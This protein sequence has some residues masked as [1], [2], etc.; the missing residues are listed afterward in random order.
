M[1]VIKYLKKLVHIF[2]YFDNFGFKDHILILQ[3]KFYQIIYVTS[4][5]FLFNIMVST[6]HEWYDIYLF[7]YINF[8]DLLVHQSP[9][10]NY[11]YNQWLI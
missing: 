10:Y 7:E 4:K 3:R 1:F 8:F 9:Y 6:W 2:E 5:L 11:Y